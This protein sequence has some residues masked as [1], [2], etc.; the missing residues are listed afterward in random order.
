MVSVVFMNNQSDNNVVD[1]VVDTVTTCSCALKDPTEMIN[2]VLRVVGDVITS[3]TNYCYIEAL[4]RYYF[5]G[6]KRQAVAGMVEVDLHVDVLMSHKADIRKSTA[7]VEVTGNAKNDYIRSDIWT[8]DVRRTTRVKK[9]TSGFNNNPE[10]ILLTAGG[11]A[12]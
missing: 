11:A 9:F 4:G 1:K 10:Y 2:P 7:L 8:P 6:N 5:V 12:N 3:Q